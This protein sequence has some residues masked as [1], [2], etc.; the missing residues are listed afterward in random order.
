MSDALARELAIGLTYDPPQANV[1]RRIGVVTAVSAG[2]VD[3]TLGGATVAGV[4][5]LDSYAPVVGDAVTVLFADNDPFVIGRVLP[6]G[7]GVGGWTP[8]TPTLTQGATVA[9]TN[10]YSKWQR[11]PGRTI[12]G[13]VFLNVTGSGTAANA[14]LIGLPVPAAAPTYTVI[15]VGNIYTGSMYKG[16]AVLNAPSSIWLWATNTTTDDVLGAAVFTGALANGNV[17]KA[18]FRYEAAA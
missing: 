5:Y 18:S 15:G 16:I 10:T 14:V 1:T 13:D 9:K 12:V 6:P 2:T 7:A 3:L 17:V 8:Y 11:L 4:A